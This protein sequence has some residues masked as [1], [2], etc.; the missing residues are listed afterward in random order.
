[1][2]DKIIISEELKQKLEKN[3]QLK[4]NLDF[5]FPET[6]IILEPHPNPLLSGEGK[7]LI[8]KEIKQYPRYKSNKLIE[9]FMVSANESI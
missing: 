8:V 7:E 2:I 5:E 3:R 6:K 4:G 9:I 1:L